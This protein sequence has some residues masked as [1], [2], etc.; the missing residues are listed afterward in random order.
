MALPAGADAEGLWKGPETLGRVSGW[1]CAISQ[2]LGGSIAG[3]TAKTIVYPLD[4]LKIRLQ[5]RSAA[6]GNSF[7]IRLLPHELRQLVRSEGVLSLWKG[8]FSAVC[9]TFPHSGIVY[10]SFD[11]YL[12]VLEELGHGCSKINRLFAGAAS[13]MTSTCITY[14]LDVLNTRMTVTRHRLSYRQVALLRYE[15]IS[16]LYRGFMPTLLGVMPYASISFFIFETLKQ[17][18]RDNEKEFTTFHSLAYGGFAG[19]LSQTITY[20][21]DSVRK[22][23]QTNSF[24]YKYQEVGHLGN[25]HLTVADSFRYIYRRGG[26]KGFYSGASLCWIKG[27]SAAGISFALNETFRGIIKSGLRSRDQ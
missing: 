27:F 20:P 22:L 14:P 15:G 5:V 12:G 21:L 3:T 24:L 9:R 7:S 18:Y 26:I 11:R 19:A 16:S 4:R 10:F 13:G 1:L 8:N 25:R 2:F 23:M 6:V 17:H